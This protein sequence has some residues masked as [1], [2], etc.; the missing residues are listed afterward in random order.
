MKKP[1]DALAGISFVS[2]HG[3]TATSK[4]SITQSRDWP[5]HPHSR[6]PAQTLLGGMR[7]FLRRLC[8]TACHQRRAARR[9]DATTPRIRSQRS[10]NL[11]SADTW[12]ETGNSK[13]NLDLNLFTGHRAPLP[14][15][16]RPPWPPEKKGDRAGRRGTFSTLNGAHSRELS[17]SAPSIWEMPPYPIH[18]TD[19]S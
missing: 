8:A 2:L 6:A 17:S 12:P 10:M 19:T 7:G 16:L 15:L 4:R 18:D 9:R 13:Q 14:R 5:E 1:H 3:S 11:P